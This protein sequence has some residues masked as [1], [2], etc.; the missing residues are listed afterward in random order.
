M[1][2]QLHNMYKAVSL[3][4]STEVEKRKKRSHKSDAFG[5]ASLGFEHQ[6]AYSFVRHGIRLILGKGSTFLLGMV[7][8][9]LHCRG[10]NK[11]RPC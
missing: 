11:H 3:V 1:A 5:L 2:E 9:L 8:F 4:S 10:L 6:L 7:L